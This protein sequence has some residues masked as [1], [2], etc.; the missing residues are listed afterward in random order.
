MKFRW[1]LLLV[2]LFAACEFETPTPTE[3]PADEVVVETEALVATEEPVQTEEP[4]ETGV[5]TENRP[6]HH[7]LKN[8]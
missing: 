8:Q 4:V 5:T 6:S 3:E 1:I 7:L 2:L